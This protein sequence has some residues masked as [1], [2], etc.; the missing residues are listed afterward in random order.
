MFARGGR[1]AAPGGARPSRVQA[2]AAVLEGDRPVRAPAPAH[3]G[4][5]RPSGGAAR[6]GRRLAFVAEGEAGAGRAGAF[7][8]AVVVAAVSRGAAQLADVPGTSNP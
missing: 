6:R 4:Y 2:G 7:A 3:G 8:C 5:V 1:R